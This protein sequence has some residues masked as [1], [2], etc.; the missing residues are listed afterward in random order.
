MIRV[1]IIA[2]GE[3]EETFVKEIL[4]DEF[5]PKIFVKPILLGGLKQYSK[6]RRDI[7]ELL[8]DKKAYTTTMIDYYGLDR[9]TGFPG[10]DGSKTISD[11]HKRVAYLEE[12]LGKNILSTR[13]IPNIVLHE[14][15]AL[16]FSDSQILSKNLGIPEAS[17]TSIL[18]EFRSN[19]EEINNSTTTAPSKRLKSLAPSYQKVL[20][21]N[22]TA[23]DIGLPTMKYHCKKFSAWVENLKKLKPIA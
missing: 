10:L 3:T 6:L 15:E 19:P 13:F 23:L 11:C 20:Q 21:G 7:L 5:F 9:V 16:L 17:I 1:N 8:K 2:E 18:K 22:L 12:A 4:Y 14:F